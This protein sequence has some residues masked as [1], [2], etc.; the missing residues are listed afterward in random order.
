MGLDFE[1][2]QRQLAID[3]RAL[4]P[5]STD[6]QKTRLQ[7][8]ANTLQRKISSWIS[9][10]HLYIPGLHVLRE[11][12]DRH[13]PPNQPEEPVSNI[14][15]YLPSAVNMTSKVACDARLQRIECDLRQA[16]AHDALHELR[17]NLRLRSHVYIDKDRFQRGQRQNTRSRGLLDRLEVKVSTA[18]AKYRAARHAI[19][20]L[21]PSLSRVGWKVEFPVLNDSDIRGLTDSSTPIHSHPSEG[22][23]AP[24]AKKNSKTLH[25]SE[26]RR[27]IT[28][29]W[30]KLGTLDNS[31]ELL[32]DDLRIE[33]CKS[34]ARGDRW[35]EEVELLQEEMKRVKRFFETQAGRWAAHA[36]A[37][38]KTNPVTDLAMAEGLRAYANEQSAQFHAMRSRC[39]HLWRYVDAYVALGRG[40]VVPKEAEGG[41]EDEN[42]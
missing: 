29:I 24:K 11:R 4:D 32:Q 30:K 33:F 27:D 1:E 41:D 25:Q 18:A 16:Q 40:E 19:S 3:L 31:D 2:Q 13:A 12:D 8:R 5:H 9:V 14:R 36:D 7:Y 6:E 28:W 34:K 10:Q 17:D 39:E 15:L 26:G 22:Q 38:G 42:T 21:A 20:T 23:E 35:A 37:V